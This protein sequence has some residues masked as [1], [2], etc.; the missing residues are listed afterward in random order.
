MCI[1]PQLDEV[2]GRGDGDRPQVRGGLSEGDPN[3]R[4]VHRRVRPQ[5][6]VRLRRRAARPDGQAHVR[7]GRGLQGKDGNFLNSSHIVLFES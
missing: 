5:P 3:G 2:C 7:P 4:G 6:Q 1:A